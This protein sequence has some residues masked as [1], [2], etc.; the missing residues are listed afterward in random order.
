MASPRPTRDSTNSKTNCPAEPL[1]GAPKL[2]GFGSSVAAFAC[3]R[4]APCLAQG[5]YLTLLPPPAHFHVHPTTFLG[6]HFSALPL[7]LP[8][9]RHIHAPCF[10][11][12]HN[13]DNFSSQ[14][15]YFIPAAAPTHL[16]LVFS[17]RARR[18]PPACEDPT[19]MAFPGQSSPETQAGSRTS[20]GRECQRSK[21]LFAGV[22]DLRAVLQS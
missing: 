11:L 2:R 14:T 7:L 6:L 18:S 12:K 4:D 19:L 21:A 9:C 17:P 16:S 3:H 5:L 22:G 8:S 15:S 13:P 10:I 1:Q 20:E